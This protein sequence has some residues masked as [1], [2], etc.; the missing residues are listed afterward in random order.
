M[1][2]NINDEN[3]VE[4]DAIKYYCKKCNK[5]VVMK[6]MFVPEGMLGKCC[7]CRGFTILK[8]NENYIQEIPIQNIP[9]CPTCQSTNI[10]RVSG[11]SKAVSVAMW[12]LLSQKVKKQFHCNNCGYEW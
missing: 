10:K 8:K 6:I 2:K 9:K 12:G 4:G 5:N 1:I 3:L 7:S 11:T